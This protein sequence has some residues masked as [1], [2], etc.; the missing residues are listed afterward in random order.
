MHALRPITLALLAFAGVA[1]AQATAPAAAVYTPYSA[2][3]SVLD[4]LRET[5]LPPALRVLT[6]PEREAA[7]PDWAARHDATIR[8]R[9]NAGDEDSLVNFILFGTTFTR[10]PRATERDLAMVAGQPDRL[11]PLMRRR[12]DDLIAAIGAPAIDE[13]LAFARQVIERKGMNPATAEGRTD[14]R[15]YLLDM[16]VRVSAEIEALS[17][18]RLNDPTIEL[19]DRL[20]R[21]RDRG[22]SSDTSIFADYGVERTLA[23]VKAAGRL[24]DVRRA[25]I[26]GPGLDFTDKHEGYD[27]YPPQT[28]QPFA[29]IDTLVRLGLADPSR[30]QLTTLD[31]SARINAHLTAAGQRAANQTS[32]VVQLPRPLDSSWSPELV[33]YW[34]RFGDRIG[35]DS[36][37]AA[38]P[39]AAGKV[40]VRALRIRPAV[41]ASVTP[42]DVNI[43]PQRLEPLAADERFDLVVATN[44]LAYYDA[45]EQSLALLNVAAMLRPG[46]ILL[47]NNGVFELPDTPLELIGS[48]DVTY[49]RL[50]DIGDTIDRLFWYQRQ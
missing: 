43:V 14:I 50:P 17:A 6:A 11:S 40:Q 4:T 44:V 19:V 48:T 29:L 20:T 15:R 8:A 27:F 22:L 46:G 28:T 9:V 10:Q 25:A 7:W 33:D 34:K 24:A 23:A 13:R 36:A 3:K 45:F 35:E 31:L 21:F 16:M 1:H 38:V 30:L 41:V 2:A 18:R 32:Y 37:P 5:L 12:T 49:M 42:R 26:I 39:A 47:T